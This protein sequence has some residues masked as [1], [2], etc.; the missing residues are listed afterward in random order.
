MPDADPTPTPP[1]R[2]ELLNEIGRG[3]M[4]VVY[5]VI[6]TALGR[7]VAVKIPQVRYGP[8]SPG[9]KRFVDE[10]RITGQLQHPGIPPVHDVGTL[11][12]GRPFLAMKLIK[13]RTLHDL[14]KERPEPAHD[15][16]RFVA[17]FE[18]VCH[19]LAYAHSHG[20]IHRDLKPANVMVG[21]FGEVQVM[22]WGLAKVLTSRERPRPANDGDSDA[23][24][25]LD[26]AARFEIHLPHSSETQAGSVLGSPAY[27]SPEQA[28]GAVDQIDTRTDVFGLG[29]LLCTILTGRPP[30]VGESAESTR[31]LAARGKLDEAFVRLGGCGAEPDLI[32]LCRRCLAIEKAD[33][34]ANA[35]EVT[36]VVAN[37]RSAAED[38]AREAE[39]ERVRIEA[40]SLAQRKRRRVV[41]IAAAALLLI[42]AAGITGTS[43]G[44]VRAS[45]ARQQAEADRDPRRPGTRPRPSGARRHDLIGHR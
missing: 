28:I 45:H 7:E 39:L 29:G 40:E 17:V 2:Y 32:D 33:R 21:G 23:T 30:Y 11:P 20:V 31:Q 14:L 4:G 13:G 26:S 44:L 34:P 27:M 1:A 37:L 19:A 42:L 38:R 36:R 12:D 35:G 18:Q 8:D 10:A 43:V 15:R 41:L 5:R 25:D 24:T 9:A 3:R 22:D 6:D 16:G